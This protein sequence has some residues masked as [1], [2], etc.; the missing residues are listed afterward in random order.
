MNK[1]LQLE[2]TIFNTI[3][4]GYRTTDRIEHWR[5]NY[6]KKNKNEGKRLLGVHSLLKA[7]LHRHARRDKTVLPVSRPLLR[8]ELDPRQLKTVA[9]RKFEVSAYSEQSSN[10]HRHTRHDTDRTVLSCL[11]WLCELSRPDRT[12]SA[13]SVGVCRAE[14]ALP[15]RPPDAL[16]RRTHLS[17]SRADSIHTA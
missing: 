1:S 4:F 2:L 8:C 12:T 10:S 3:N 16:R 6:P 15:V 13:F 17:G 11:V 7:N 5:Q 9:D 14:Q